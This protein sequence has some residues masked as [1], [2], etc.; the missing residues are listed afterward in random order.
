[1]RSFFEQWY[2]RLVHF[3][4]VRLGDADQAEDLAQEAFVRLVRNRPRHPAAW[5]FR[6]AENL[7]RDE[8]RLARGRA[9]HLTLIQVE[10][11]QEN[12]PGPEQELLRR[13]DVAHVRRVLDSLPTRDRTL[14]LLH[15]EGLRYRE[16]AQQLGLAPA[17]IGSLLTRAER[18]FLKSYG[19]ARESEER[20]ASG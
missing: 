4:Y 13:D 9:R 1:M 8:V 19:A 15:Y 10:Q 2:P 18:R 7:I 16:I 3:V 5:L 20:R 17:S 11:S 6:V 12:D 14:L